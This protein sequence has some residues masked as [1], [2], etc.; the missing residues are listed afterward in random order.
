MPESLA[1]QITRKIE[2][3]AGLLRAT[4]EAIDGQNFRAV[5]PLRTGRGGNNP[6]RQRKH[7]KAKA[8]RRDVD[9]EYHLHYWETENG[10]EFASMAVHNNFTIP[11]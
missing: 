4:S 3:A 5:H 1:D 9:H 10:I 6:Q 11:E 8:C 7:D 2:Q